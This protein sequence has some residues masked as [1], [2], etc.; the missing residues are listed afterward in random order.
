MCTAACWLETNLGSQEQKPE[1]GPK[2]CI[3]HRCLKSI[4]TVMPEGVLLKQG[5]ECSSH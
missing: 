5:G 2:N 4:E 3:G 1:L